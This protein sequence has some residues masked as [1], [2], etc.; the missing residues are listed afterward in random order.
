MPGSISTNAPIIGQAGDL[1]GNNRAGRIFLR[2][3]RPW[4]GFGL[5][6]TQRNFLLFLVDVQHDHFDFVAEIEN[7]ARDG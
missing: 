3:D 6:E 5:L 1:G 4:I 7:I 2:S